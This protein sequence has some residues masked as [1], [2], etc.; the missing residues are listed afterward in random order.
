MR[1]SWMLAAALPAAV[2]AETVT[3]RF[4]W[5]AGLQAEV[6]FS[7]VRERVTGERRD[8]SET[9]GRYALVTRRVADGLLVR[10]GDLRTDTTSVEGERVQ[11][12][13]D[14]LSNALPDYV[15]DDSGSLVRVI[16]TEQ[17]LATL[18]ATVDEAVSEQ[19]EELREQIGRALRAALN[20]Q[21]LEAS[22]RSHWSRDVGAWAGLTVEPG[23]RYEGDAQVPVPM[24]SGQAVTALVR[25]R[26]AGRIACPPPASERA[27]VVLEMR[28]FVAG[29][30]AA[31]VIERLAASLSARSGRAIEVR[32]LELDNRVRLTTEPDTLLPHAVEFERRTAIEIATDGRPAREMS[33]S[34]TRRMAYL[35]RAR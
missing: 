7:E 15:V 6:E 20:A 27:C 19:P 13:V 21:H 12:V 18:R 35:Y 8:R 2:A 1:W 11:A 26:M 22:L 14:R 4:D 31:S 9:S 28:T 17:L 25:Y 23:R 33:Q 30:Q 3:L 16:G 10:V 24:L 29:E 34:E 32:S 5:P